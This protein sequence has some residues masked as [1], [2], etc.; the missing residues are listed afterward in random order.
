MTSAR[1]QGT[2][3]YLLQH[4]VLFAMS[5]AGA[6][7]ASGYSL[8]RVTRTTGSR[9]FGFAVLGV[10]TAAEGAGIVLGRRR[11]RR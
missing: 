7:A 10:L 3:H 2:G 1:A 11:A 5:V 6:G 4:P 9:R 8:F